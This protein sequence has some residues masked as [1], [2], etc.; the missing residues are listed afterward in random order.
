MTNLF[1]LIDSFLGKNSE[2]P[3]KFTVAMG[4]LIRKARQEENITQSELAEKTYFR[5]AAISDIENGKREATSSELL[6]FSVAL[7][8]P[9]TYFFPEIFINEPDYEHLTLLEKELIIHARHLQIDDLRRVI[10]Q[11]KALVDLDLQS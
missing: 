11:V 1:D 3:N 9:I 8:K 6:Y 7:N 4:A 2:L 10:A 5:Q